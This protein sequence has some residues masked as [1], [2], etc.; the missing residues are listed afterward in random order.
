L[1]TKAQNAAEALLN[2]EGKTT[3]A[4]STVVSNS[5]K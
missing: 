4:V 3:P 2:A 1:D 5:I